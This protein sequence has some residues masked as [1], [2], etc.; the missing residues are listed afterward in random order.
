M[1]KR[2]KELWMTSIAITDYN[3]IYGANE[4]YN[5]CKK[6]E[7]KPILGLEVI[8]VQNIQDQKAPENTYIVLLAK[9]YEWYQNLI[10]LSTASATIWLFERPRI[11]LSLLSE[12]SKWLVCL[13]STWDKWRLYKMFGNYA[14]DDKIMDQI[15]LMDNILWPENIYIE[16]VAQDYKKEKGLSDCNA[17]ANSLSQKTGKKLIVSNNFH[18]IKPDD[19]IAF[20]VALCIKDGLQITSPERR[21]V[22]GDY[23]IF[24]EEEIINTM[25]ANWDSEEYIYSLIKN[26]EDLVDDIN[27]KFPDTKWIYHFPIYQ[28]PEDISELYKQFQNM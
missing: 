11:D 10:K 23:H 7:L 27:I 13:L 3:A 21:K 1:A 14:D 24:S 18:Y 9:D 16:I 15:K 25:K 2:V 19:K 20:E 17:R 5:I 8:M 4:F 22:L 6:V 12:Y 28:T 26:N